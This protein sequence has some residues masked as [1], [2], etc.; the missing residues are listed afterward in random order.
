MSSSSEV[1]SNRALNR[2]TLAR[3]M[4]L[5]R[6]AVTPA[7][8]VQR[9]AG[10]QAQEPRPPFIGLW[11]RIE[12]GQREAMQ[13]GMHQRKLVRGTLMR[14]TIHLVTAADYAAF[15]P[16]IQPVLDQGMAVL[17]ERA[18]GLEDDEDRVL[19]RA[20]EL[21]QAEPRTFAELRSRLT[22]AFPHINDRALGH[23][24]RMKLALV[25]EPIEHPWAYAANARFTLAESWL[26]EPLAT[27]ADPAALA[28]RYLAAFG[29][30]TVADVQIWSGLRNLK[31]VMESL[32]PQLLTFRNEQGKELFDLPD[33]PRPDPETPAPVRF[34]PEFDNLLLS[35]ADRTRVIA[36]EHR[37]IIYQKGNL[38]LLSSFL[39]DGRVAG[40]W[41][42]E[43]KKQAATLALSPFLPLPRR[44]LT[45]LEDEGERLLRFL[46]PAATTHDIVVK[47]AE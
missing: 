24:V 4:L 2:A 15:R 32:R 43:A 28:L 41:R 20:S 46:E 17:G 40:L 37:G 9:L 7:V 16:T 25:L 12:D 35:H 31:P 26:E 21:L 18:E 22:E 8:A 6:A 36:D 5:E 3:Q 23:L 27:V 42:V 34:L 29:P 38:R 14:G 11:S 33:A 45:E 19:A 13:R 10:M 1:L 39:V 47:T 30:A 44:V